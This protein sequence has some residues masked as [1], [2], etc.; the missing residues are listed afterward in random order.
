MSRVIDLS[1]RVRRF[2]AVGLLAALAAAS[3][4]M[5]A[6][7]LLRWSYRST[8][9]LADA[10]FDLARARAIERADKMLSTSDVEAAERET[11]S[12]LLNG[13][14]EAEASGHL[15]AAVDGLLRSEHLTVENAQAAPTVASGA[16]SL[17]ALDWRGFGLEHDVV[18]AVAALE[19]ARP[20]LR[21]ERLVLRVM[22]DGNVSP[23]DDASSRL[24]IELRVTGLWI[25]PASAPSPAPPETPR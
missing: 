9:D 17:V 10:R 22:D 19:Q 2:V 23:H 4:T 3:F 11:L 5:L 18:H 7:Q 6:P 15:H 25:P 21:I 20:L 16:I 12:S 1:P 24:G 13:A 8:E 14:S